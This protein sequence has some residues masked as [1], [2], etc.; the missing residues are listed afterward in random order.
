MPLIQTHGRLILRNHAKIYTAAQNLR[1][2]DNLIDRNGKKKFT[3]TLTANQL[4]DLI[5]IHKHFSLKRV[6]KYIFENPPLLQLWSKKD[7]YTCRAHNWPVM[8]TG[9]FAVF[10]N[11]IFSKWFIKEDGPEIFNVTYGYGKKIEKLGGATQTENDLDK[12]MLEVKALVTKIGDLSKLTFK[13]N[14]FFFM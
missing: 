4:V 10:K 11:Q 8:K 7:I 1:Q 5:K 12:E 2:K 9:G 3:H 13:Q 6:D 14:F